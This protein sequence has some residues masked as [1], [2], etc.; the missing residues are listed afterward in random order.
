MSNF[1]NLKPL[2]F[3]LF[4]F[5]LLS[6]SHAQV[7][8]DRSYYGA[9]NLALAGSAV[10]AQIDAWAAFNNPS[11]L[12]WINSISGAI[13]YD[14]GFSQDFLPHS[15]AVAVLPVG[16]FGTAGIY[17]DRSSVSYS[18]NTLASELALSFCHGFFL[19]KD[20]N[21]TLALGY[22]LKYLSVDYG[23]S[24]GV[25]GDGSDGIDLGKSQTL[26]LDVGFTAT[27]R[28]RHRV[29]ARAYNLNR[30]QLGQAN[31]AVDL[32]WT[33]QVGVAYS[34]YDLVWTTAALNRTA[35]H[36]TQYS[37]GLEY[38]VL[39]NLKLLAGVQSN[40]NRLGLGSSI[41][42]LSFNISYGLL[43]HPVLPLT[44]QFSLGLAF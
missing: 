2:A 4:I 24:A 25:S 22:N 33:I 26:G 28:E 1:M 44:H 18:G 13:G 34:P 30:P 20:G 37:A 7:T 19:Q 29:A 43:T 16:R 23:T 36:P 38:R 32:P 9:R 40:P 27:L 6:C 41:E 5:H 35:G 8:S 12:A 3:Y 39:D 21:S 11:G 15:T 42:M 14:R 17:L 31:Y 10:A